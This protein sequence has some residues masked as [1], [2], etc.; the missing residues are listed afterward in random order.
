M[1]VT[2]DLD[3]WILS[4]ACTQTLNTTGKLQVASVN[5]LHSFRVLLASS[6]LKA[7]LP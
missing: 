2:L 5:Y 6:L 3:M 1:V 4:A 7:A